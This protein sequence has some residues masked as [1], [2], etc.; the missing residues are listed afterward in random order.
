MRSAAVLSSEMPPGTG[1]GI[2]RRVAILGAA[3]LLSVFVA[4]AAAGSARAAT[5]VGL[6]TAASYGVLAGSGVTNTGPSVINGDLGTFPTPAVTGFEGAPNGTVNGAIHQGDAAAS[7]A[8]NDLTTAYNNA[9]GQGPP[10]TLATELGGKTLTPGVYTSQSGTFGITGTLTL[11]AQGDPDAVF[12][13]KTASTLIS[14][15]ASRVSMIN[16]AQS[17][18]LFWKVGSSA[19][20]GTSSAFAGNILALQSISLND[21]VSVSG[22]LLARNG[23]VTLINDTVTRAACS[24]STGGSGGGNGGGG[25]GGWRRQRRRREQRRRQVRRPAHRRPPDRERY[26][27][28]QRRTPDHELSLHRHPL[29]GKAQDPPLDRNAQHQGLRRRQA[30]QAGQE[31]ADDLLGKRVRTTGRPQHDPGARRRPRRAPLQLEPIVP[32]L[33]PG[34]AGPGLHRL[35][36]VLRHSPLCLLGLVAAL[37]LPASAGA[38]NAPLPKDSVSL[39]NETTSTRW[40]HPTRVAAIRWLPSRR[41]RRMKSTHP[42]TEDGFPEVYVVLSAWRDAEGGNWLRIRIPMRPNGR[43]G[44]VRRQVLGPLY[45]VRTQLI[46]NRSSR[47]ATL[48]RR[49]VPIWSA[50]VGIG[51]PSTPTPRGHFWIREKFRTG[52]PS[53]LYGPVA[54]G[55]SDYSVL[56]DWPGGGVIGIHGTAEPSLIPGRPSHGCI[57]VKNHAIRRL[58]RLLPVGTP[59]LIRQRP[60]LRLSGAIAGRPRDPVDLG[61]P[62]AAGGGDT[63]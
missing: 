34:P 2:R 33:R 35:T 5:S 22:R 59:L 16:G 48:F 38:R 43:T 56:S 1:P 46:L 47:H 40:A 61:D 8:K 50:P 29:P 26:R 18:H 41:A 21:G 58:W 63:S 14:A 24:A 54:F 17:C 39:S 7:Q 51:K 27:Q 20:L 6:G 52:E 57:R 31:Q 12:I 53:G 23:A 9:A 62:V 37:A 25:N 60:P 44:W 36:A 30:D 42:R 32:P 55:S 3:L 11:N 45:R 19:T 49:G 15:S 28:P 4:I 13:F 10:N